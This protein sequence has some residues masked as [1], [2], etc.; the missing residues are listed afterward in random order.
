LGKCT[1]YDE[2]LSDKQ[3]TLGEVRLSQKY[4][5]HVVNQLENQLSESEAKPAIEMIQELIQ[6]I[7]I[8]ILIRPMSYMVWCCF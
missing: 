7:L 1:P 3:R 8:L 4:V 6:L 5:N 2:K